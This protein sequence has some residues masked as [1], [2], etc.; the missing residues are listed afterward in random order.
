M[1]GGNAGF[2]WSKNLPGNLSNWELCV[3]LS[4]YANKKPPP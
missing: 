2:A 3:K 4:E 1:D